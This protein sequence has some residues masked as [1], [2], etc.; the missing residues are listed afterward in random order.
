MFKYI[1]LSFIEVNK[2]I[3][4]VIIAKSDTRDTFYVVLLFLTT[5]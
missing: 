5:R 4:T 1:K 2:H 3:I